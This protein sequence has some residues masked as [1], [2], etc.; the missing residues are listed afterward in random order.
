MFASRRGYRQY[1]DYDL[2]A[3]ELALIFMYL[4]MY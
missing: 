3:L 4:A 2:K 1:Y